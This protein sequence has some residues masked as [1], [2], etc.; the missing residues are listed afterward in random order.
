[1]TLIRRRVE[2]KQITGDI[3]ETLQFTTIGFTSHLFEEMMASAQQ[4]TRDK[5][6][7]RTVIYVSAGGKWLR[8]L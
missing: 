8:Q 4:Y 7:D 6:S 2:A 3:F 5:D 1:M